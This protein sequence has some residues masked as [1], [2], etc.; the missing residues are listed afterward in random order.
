MRSL[1]FE[2]VNPHRKARLPR[3]RLAQLCLLSAVLMWA[4]GPI[5]LAA[6][7]VPEQSGPTPSSIA[8]G[9]PAGS[10]VLSGFDTVNLF[11]GHLN[12]QFPIVTI[13]G[14]GDAGYTM[15]LPLPPP[16]FSVYSPTSGTYTA[17][18]AWTPPD[19]YTPGIMELRGGFQEIT[20]GNGTS[21]GS[22]L[23]TF[24]V[25]SDQNGSEHTLYDTSTYGY[26]SAGLNCPNPPQPINRGTEFTSTDGS[27]LVYVSNADI[28]DADPTGPPLNGHLYFGNGRAYEITGGLVTQIRDRNG[29]L[30]T[31]SYENQGTLGQV[32]DIDTHR[33]LSVV[34]PLGRPATI[35][36][37]SSGL[38]AGCTTITYAGKTYQI[39]Q[40]P[41][42]TLTEI[43]NAIKAAGQTTPAWLVGTIRPDF[44]GTGGTSLSALSAL[45]ASS[46][47]PIGTGSTWQPTVISSLKLP[48]QQSYSF[49]Y[50]ALGDLAQ[51]TLPTG[52]AI[53]YD[54][55]WTPGVNP[56]GT[57]QLDALGVYPSYTAYYRLHQRR[58][59]QNATDSL[60]Q[61]Q[62]VYTTQTL[63]SNELVTVTHED[64]NGNSLKIEQHT[65][66]SAPELEVGSNYTHPFGFPTWSDGLEILSQEFSPG[67]TATPLRSVATMWG[68]Q[69]FTQAIQ[70]AM[71]RFPSGTG[72][73]TFNPRTSQISTTLDGITSG[74]VFCYDNTQTFNNQTDVW[75]Y[76]FGFS[77]PGGCPAANTGYVRHKKTTYFTDPNYLADAVHLVSLPVTQQVMDGGDNVIAETD[78]PYDLG[79][80]TS[81]SSITGHTTSSGIMTSFP[82]LDTAHTWRGNVTGVKRLVAGAS[83][84]G[85]SATYDIAGNTLTSVD[86]NGKQ[87]TYSY[88]DSWDATSALWGGAGPSGYQYPY[89]SNTWAF[90]T[91]VTNALNQTTRMTYAYNAGKA[92][93]VTDPN[94]AKTTYDYS[95]AGLLQRLTSITYPINSTA[96]YIY[97]DQ[98]GS[99]SVRETKTMTAT[100]S[101]QCDA[102]SV[103]T[104]T[105]YD[106]LGRQTTSQVNGPNGWIYTDR[107]YDGLGRQNQ[108][109][110]PYESGGDVWTTTT[111]DVLNR[112]LS[113]TTPDSSATY[114]AYSAYT[115]SGTYDQTV[116][117]DAAQNQ[118]TTYTDGLGRLM[119]VLAQGPSSVSVQTYTPA[120]YTT[121]YLY[122]ALDD[123]TQVTP[124]QSSLARTFTYD[125]LSRL[126]QATN[127]EN[128]T[129]S[130]SAYD[131]NG[132]LLTKVA[133]NIT[134][135]YQYDALNRL[136]QK[137]YS[138]GVTP[139]VGY[140]YDTDM[141]LPGDGATNYPV[142][143]LSEVSTAA[144]GNAAA[145]DMIYTH[146]DAMGRVTGSRQDAAGA[147]YLFSYI[148]NDLNLDTEVYPSLRKVESCY[149]A[150]GRI[151][152]LLNVTQAPSASYASLAYTLV[153]GIAQTTKTLGNT[154]V[155]N[156]TTNTRL[157]TTQIQLG[158]G[159]GVFC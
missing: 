41:L 14:R 39:C 21:I 63:N 7:S 28:H 45:L 90:P 85:T 146:Y 118:R 124:S 140:I 149:D 32:D 154:L 65:F 46:N 60:P 36:Y 27:N 38:L 97:N 139:S 42:G 71:N 131:G 141:R 117:T 79:T 151:S 133:N 2:S 50:D 157:Q 106:G 61:Q 123:L 55:A 125:G 56:S 83:Y 111:Y 95:E 5:P 40:E 148:Y 35:T 129:V 10:Y 138:D 16:F 93:S 53:L 6:Q 19:Q 142:G 150:A 156:E 54:Y 155:E 44:I 114:S 57:G 80:I 159:A 132:N 78:Y 115:A 119:R 109:S 22:N 75:E 64:S 92:V 147:P 101:V 9:S 73:I 145:T 89:G 20:C 8:P 70:T 76:G 34:D 30:T 137:S 11:N 98:P 86:G 29:N 100:L 82:A 107:T 31:L 136:S 144:L 134:T 152:Q 108:V 12:V 33:L 130:Y 120:D 3:S 74:Q 126:T 58:T 81:E 77:S 48:N 17:L 72:T 84:V 67:N 110:N 62:V 102:G 37:Q 59:Y 51:I 127:P 25:F 68:E 4:G 158:A 18:P 143:R 1:S 49:L 104:K 135:T 69:P 121:N 88:A 153:G 43:E 116:V 87:T 47:L 15:A 26:P 128:G 105:F 113:V 122:D 52:G 94:F 91:S 99:V 112:P 66:N 23:S 24:L 96:S 13:G 103:Q